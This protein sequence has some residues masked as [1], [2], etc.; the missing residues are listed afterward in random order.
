MKRK[1]LCRQSTQ[2]LNILP[3]YKLTNFVEGAELYKPYTTALIALLPTGLN[4]VMRAYEVNA[5]ATSTLCCIL[6]HG[7]CE[8]K[9][10]FSFGDANTTSGEDLQGLYWGFDYTVDTAT[11]N[12]LCADNILECGFFKWGEAP[13]HRAMLADKNGADRGFALENFYII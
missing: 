2:M 7:E 11:S 9:I 5:D 10:S 3:V 13:R 8:H 4:V 12:I 1:I 6:K